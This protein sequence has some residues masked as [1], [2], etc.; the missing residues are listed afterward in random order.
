MAPVILG[1]VDSEIGILERM[2]VRMPEAES[3]QIFAWRKRTRHKS[4]LL[5]ELKVRQ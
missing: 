3:T 2:Q 1:R 5:Q 4:V